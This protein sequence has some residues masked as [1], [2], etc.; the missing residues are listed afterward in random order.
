MDGWSLAADSMLMGGSDWL[1]DG[2]ALAAFVLEFGGLALVITERVISRKFH[3][4][5]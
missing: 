1:L 4:L 3:S 5:E 2:P